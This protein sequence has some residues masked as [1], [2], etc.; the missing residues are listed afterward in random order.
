MKYKISTDKD[1]YI[2][3]IEKDEKGIDIDIS[4]M[5]LGFL[6]CYQLNDNKVV[7]DTEKYQSILNEDEKQSRISE[8]LKELEQ[9]DYVQDEFINSLLSLNNPVTFITDILALMSN[10]MKEYPSIIAERKSLIAELKTLI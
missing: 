2:I 6:N 9:T 3:K 7:L 8:I 1:G 5:L 10:V 4:S